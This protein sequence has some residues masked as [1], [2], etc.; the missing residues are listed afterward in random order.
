ETCGEVVGM[1]RER[2]K[3]ALAAVKISPEKYKSDIQTWLSAA[4]TLVETCKDEA[5]PHAHMSEIYNK[6]NQTSRSASNALAL[7]NLI[8]G[9][10]SL[11][12]QQTN[13]FPNWVSPGQRKLLQTTGLRANAVVSKDGSGNFKTVA[14]AIA[15]AS[16]G[17]GFVIYV[18][19][20]VY[21]EQVVCRKSGITLIGDGKYSTIISGGK[22]VGGGSSLLG[23]STFTIYG[24]GFVARDIGFE[25]TAPPENHQAVAL[26]VASD[27]SVFYRCSFS[28]Y[29]DTLFA[30]SLRQFYREC[31]VQGTIDFI[32]GNA[33]A[34]FQNSNLILRQPPHG[35]YNAI[36]ANGRTDPG[37][38][39]GFSVHN[40]KIAV[41]S[42]GAYQSYLG[43]PWKA[44]SRAVVMKS[45]IDGA[46]SGK[47]WS[48]WEGA[49]SSTYTTLYFAEYAN[50]GGGSMTGGRVGWP[51]FHVIGMPEAAK[52]TVAA[53]I[54][55]DSWLPPT[56]V[57]FVSGL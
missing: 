40:C 8:A 53:F 44:Y 27:R 42:R 4:V 19:A 37:Q 9:N 39:T 17:G 46:I 43:R 33:A 50:R 31:D 16:G 6:M 26:T 36:L 41:A 32:F 47:G 24:D 12:P 35:G 22:S 56:G 3:Q 20:G 55:G 13:E 34:V 11:P 57:A 21:S 15:A 7:S 1:S 30:L 29:Q 25:N 14:E 48:Q 28:S 51:G 52:F 49:G 5:E 23:S 54:G 45:D 10:A 18:K 2:L 38:N